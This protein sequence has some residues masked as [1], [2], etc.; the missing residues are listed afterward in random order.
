MFL[1]EGKRVSP[2]VNCVFNESEV[3]YYFIYSED[4]PNKIKVIEMRELKFTIFI[5]VGFG[6][7]LWK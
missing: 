7:L 1:Y 4:I 6:F 5:C 3:I 2:S